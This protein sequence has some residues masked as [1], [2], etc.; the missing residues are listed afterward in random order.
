MKKW[1]ETDYHSPN[2]TIKPDWNWSG[3]QTL[4]QVGMIIG[5]RVANADA[6]PV[7]RTTSPYN[8]PRG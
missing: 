5:F 3:P 8:R 7:W 2:D 4:A 1:L 6:M